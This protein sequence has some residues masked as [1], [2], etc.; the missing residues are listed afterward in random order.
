MKRVSIYFTDGKSLAFNM[1]ISEYES[2]IKWV[3]DYNNGDFYIINYNMLEYL[4]R[5]NAIEYIIA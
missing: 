5:K 2:L 4:I 3:Y 1:E